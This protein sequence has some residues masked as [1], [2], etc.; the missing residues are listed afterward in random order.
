M[1]KIKVF[2]DVYYYKAALSGIRTYITELKFASENHSSKNIDYIFS[3]DLDKLSYNQL[4]L[5][6]SNQLIRW[7]FQFNYLIWKQLILPIK[8]LWYRP[9]YLICPDYVSPI[10]SFNT[11]KLTV[12]HDSLFWDYPNN[13]RPLWRKYFISLINFGINNRTKIITTS[14]YSKNNLLKVIKKTNSIDYVYQSFENILDSKDNFESKIQ[15]PESY[16]L[17]I[18][19]FEKR[20]DLITLV[21]AFHVIKKQESNKK[22]K[23]VLAGA[24]VVNGNKKTINEIKRYILNADLEN[25]IILPNY[26]SKEEA[27]TYYKNALMYVFPSID[28][29]FGIPIIEAF[30]YCLPIIC[31]DIPVFKE[32]GNNSVSY[33]KK[34]DFI[35]LSEKIQNLIN[36][37]DLRKELS[38]KGKGQLIKFSRKNFIRGFEDLI[39]H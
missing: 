8:L 5:N 22:I 31:S 3:H 2:I 28:E 37:E 14:N 20:K 32:I 34:G 21:K 38:L 39:I 29:G 25:E 30:S 33:F 11:K 36:S 12:I 18:G 35:S 23:L 9:E 1:K 7:L 27:H 13:Y 10:L 6:S 4:Y 16:I 24:Q 17:H 26:I 19:S 15:L